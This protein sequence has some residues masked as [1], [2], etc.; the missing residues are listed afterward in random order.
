M[1][2]D[3]IIKFERRKPKKNPRSV[4]PIAYSDEVGH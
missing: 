2:D 4:S 1:R 3:N